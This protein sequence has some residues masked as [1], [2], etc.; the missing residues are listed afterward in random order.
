M[1]NFEKR[2]LDFV[3]GNIAKNL[4]LFALPIVAGEILQNLYNSV[5]SLVVGRYVSDSALAA[6]S[7]CSN[8]SNLIIAAF[9]GLTIGNTVV[10][11]QVVGKGEKE[12]TNRYIKIIFTFSVLLGVSLSVLGV[13]FAPQ[14]I[15]LT[16][17]QD[18]IYDVAMTYLRIYLSGI[19]FTVIYNCGAG[20]LRALG[21]SVSPFNILCISS[22]L[23]I[24]L[25]FCFV[26]YL[27]LGVFG[28]GLATVV[29]Q[30][31]SAFMIYLAI[32]KHTNSG[33]IDIKALFSE[34]WPVIGKALKIGIPPSFYGAFLA[35]SNVFVWRYINAFSTAEVAGIGVALKVEKFTTVCS[36][37][38]GN[39][40]TAY[41][42]QNV[43]AKKY[44][45]IKKGIWV[46]IIMNCAVVLFIG[47]IITF[48]SEPIVGLFD[49]NP[50]V[51][52]AGSAMLLWLC[53]F[54]PFVSIREVLSGALRAK[55]KTVITTIL[56]LGGMVVIRQIF[57]YFAAKS[58]MGITMI[59][60]AYPV[61]W[62]VS[63][64]LI[65]AYYFIVRKSYYTED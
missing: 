53:P 51:I 55:G 39:A 26:K 25:D 16:A 61:G 63:S 46:C 29:A 7:V 11:G 31:L 45:R 27:N 13:I 60:L 50:A 8:L 35:V 28:V 33:A 14:L 48:F 41:A 3:N 22:A 65:I 1:A 9:N 47:F 44:D 20:S 40:M 62:V 2:K 5:D 57:L 42:S 64:V 49:S 58:N 32:C 43:G 18:D 54:Y 38:F 12:S 36:K 37:G 59:Y 4:Y 56:S 52:A 24:V 10:I 23:N 17:A 15:S 34:G 21:D 6:V 19:M 30:S